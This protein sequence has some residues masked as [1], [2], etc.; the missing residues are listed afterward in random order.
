[1]K[2]KDNPRPRASDQE[3]IVKQLVCAAAIIGFALLPCSPSQAAIEVS[4]GVY[5]NGGARLGDA[6]Y[7]LCCT[8][9]QAA[10]GVIGPG[11]GSH[12]CENG[13]WHATWH[14][15]ADVPDRLDDLPLQFELGHG[16]PNSFGNV[17]S[18]RYATPL[19]THVSIRLFDVTGRAVQTLVDGPVVP[20]YHASAL[21]TAGLNAGVYFCRMRAG[22]FSA[23]GRLMLIK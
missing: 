6:T 19:H 1:L 7:A 15:Y 16:R 13:F 9:G 21:R 18:I 23:T 12:I 11:A 5:S 2:T 10:I 22:E 20:G 8:A 17:T 4:R 14:A 3:G